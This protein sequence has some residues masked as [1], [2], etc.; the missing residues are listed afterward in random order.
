M[1]AQALRPQAA[2]N[3]ARAATPKPHRHVCDVVCDKASKLSTQT[4][5]SK[6]CDK[7]KQIVNS[8]TKF[9]IVVVVKTKQSDAVPSF[10][11]GAS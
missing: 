5:S 11:D 9:K 2:M 7:S 10:H 6:Y 1:H 4:Q 8:N 3:I